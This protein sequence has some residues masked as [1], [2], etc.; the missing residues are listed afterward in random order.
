MANSK[1]PYKVKLKQLNLETLQA[2]RD[3]LSLRFSENCV[4]NPRTKTM[5]KENKKEHKIKLRKK[6]SFSSLL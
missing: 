5:F 2:R 1:D 3:K 4:K 6:K